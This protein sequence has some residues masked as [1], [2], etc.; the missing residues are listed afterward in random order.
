MAS[1]EMGPY[2]SLLFIKNKK[3][4][5]KKLNIMKKEPKLIFIGKF[6]PEFITMIMSIVDHISSKKKEKISKKIDILSIDIIPC[7]ILEEKGDKTNVATYI[8]EGSE[9]FVMEKLFPSKLFEGIKEGEKAFFFTAIYP[10]MMEQGVVSAK[11]YR[12][13]FFWLKEYLKK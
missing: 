1:L 3:T 5:L 9:G 13:N 12:K 7:Y 8:S 2:H 4:N 11:R 6:D 10:G